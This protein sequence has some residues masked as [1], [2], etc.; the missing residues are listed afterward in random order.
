MQIDLQSGTPLADR[1]PG[2][3]G[4]TEYFRIRHGQIAQTQYSLV[5]P[6]EAVT[7]GLG[8]NEADLDAGERSYSGGGYSPQGQGFGIFQG[9]SIFGNLFGQPQRPMY[10]P[11]YQYPYG[12]SQN[13]GAGRPQYPGT[14]QYGDLRQ[15]NND[16]RRWFPPS[17]IDPDVPEWLRRDRQRPE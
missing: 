2:A 9:G 4:F 8:D 16:D 10:A 13:P 15:P 12:Q 7:I 6:N 14:S 1:G 3:E 5:S 17:R 11:Q